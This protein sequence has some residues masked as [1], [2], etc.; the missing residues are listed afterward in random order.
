MFFES[1]S[2][3]PLS[4]GD[5]FFREVDFEIGSIHY[6]ALWTYFTLILNPIPSAIYFIYKNHPIPLCK[7]ILC[8]LRNVLYQALFFSIVIGISLAESLPPGENFSGAIGEGGFTEGGTVRVGV[9]RWLMIC[10]H[11]RVLAVRLS[12]SKGT[13]GAHRPGPFLMSFYAALIS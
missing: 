9:G 1:L 3:P 13:K 6:P 5:G 2:G 12:V 11:K 10:R 8:F 7:A 4:R